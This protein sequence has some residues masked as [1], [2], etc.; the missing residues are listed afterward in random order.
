MYSFFPDALE[1]LL[2]GHAASLEAN[3]PQSHHELVGRLLLLLSRR[4]C[5]RVLREMVV[6]QLE[7]V[8]SDEECVLYASQLVQATKWDTHDFNALARFLLRKALESAGFAHVLYWQL[9]VRTPLQRDA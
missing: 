7:A 4:N 3:S 6:R 9:Q 5:D 1:G 8:L 2:R